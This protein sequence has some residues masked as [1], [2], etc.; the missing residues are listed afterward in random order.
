MGMFT[1]LIVLYE[2]ILFAIADPPEP[3]AEGGSNDSCFS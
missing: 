2:V 3:G 1:I